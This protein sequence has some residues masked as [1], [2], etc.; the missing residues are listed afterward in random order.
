MVQVLITID[1]E[2]SLGGAWENPSLKPIDPE[3]SVLGKIGSQYYGTPRIMDILEKNSLRGTFFVEVF[4]AMNGSRPALAEAY[5]QIAKRGHDVQLHLHPIHYYYHLRQEG[6]LDL[7]RLPKDKDMFAAHALEKQVEMLKAGVAIFQD[8]IGESPVAFR[9]GNFGADLDTLDALEKV[10]IRFDS[11]FNASYT[12]TDCKLDSSG[13]VNL[14]WKHGNIWEVPITN[15]QTGKWGLRALKQLNINAVS[16][17]EMKSVLDQ[18]ER[19]GLRTVNFIAHSFSLFKIGDV[20]FRKLTPDRLAQRR[21][22]GLCRYL[23][24]NPDRF[25]VV[26]FSD[27][28]TASLPGEEKEIPKMGVIVPFFRK[29]VQAINRIPWV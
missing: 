7:E 27:L 5:S 26:G 14:S 9:A 21:L 17:W 1:T 22:Q 25:R 4:A 11:S 23:M 3:L 13:A 18:A 6:R 19:I 28:D 24:E 10:G 15:F 20:Q 12:Q 2:C 16:L 8:M 29:G